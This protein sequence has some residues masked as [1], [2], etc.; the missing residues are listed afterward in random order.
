MALEGRYLVQLEEDAVGFAPGKAAAH[1]VDELTGELADIFTMKVERRWSDALTGFSA[2]MTEAEARRLARHP[3][4]VRVQQD[5]AVQA[6]SATDLCTST[7]AHPANTRP[8]PAPLFGS[9]WRQS[10]DCVNPLGT[11]PRFGNRGGPDL[12]RGQA[13]EHHRSQNL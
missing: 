13:G 1:G 9:V 6:S 8:L 3:F 11:Y 10:I 2:R 12:R 5:Y 4:V 7:G